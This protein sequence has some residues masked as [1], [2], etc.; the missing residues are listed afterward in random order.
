MKS[1]GLIIH[2]LPVLFLML[3]VCV[4]MHSSDK[5][6]SQGSNTV[7]IAAL[8]TQP[9]IDVKGTWSGTFISRH[10]DTSPFTITVKINSDLKGHLIGDSSLNSD[11]LKEARL[12]VT[13]NGSEIVLAG[14]DKEGDNIT[15]RGSIDNTGTLL[16]L[17]YIINAS[18]SARC[19]TDDGT[20][21]MGKR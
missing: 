19:E 9:A 5:P 16:T 17:S 15:F 8:S 18:A 6:N 14:G 12:Q 20:G 21:T 11:C 4:E 13:V 1:E 2:P 10:S 7:S 3:V